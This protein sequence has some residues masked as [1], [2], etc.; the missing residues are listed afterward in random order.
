[1]TVPDTRSVAVAQ[2]A[3]S[4]V[5]QPQGLASSPATQPQTARLAQATAKVEEPSAETPVKA[6]DA[7]KPAAAP[8]VLPAGKPGEVKTAE[9]KPG[10]AKP[11]VVKAQTKEAIPGL[12]MS[13]NAY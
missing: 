11:T 6:A 2:V 5:Y 10:E 3:P 9:A 12:R 13:A 1:M 8:K 7:G 4:A